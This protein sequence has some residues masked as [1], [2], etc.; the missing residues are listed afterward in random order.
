MKISAVI[1]YVSTKCRYYLQLNKHN[2][3]IMFPTYLHIVFD[4]ITERMA[5]DGGN[6]N[7]GMITIMINS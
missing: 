5:S 1:D 3:T 6:V 4:K 2:F 7:E